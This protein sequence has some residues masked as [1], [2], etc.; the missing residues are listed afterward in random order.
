LAPLVRA[1]AVEKGR[2]P[3]VDSISGVSG[4]GKTPSPR[5]HFCE[6]SVQ[7][8]NVMKHRHNPEIDQACGT[9]VVFTPHLG[10]YSRG[11]VSTM[12]VDLAPGWTGA[13]VGETYKAAYAGEPFVRLLPAGEWPS[14]QGVE[15]TNFCDIGW[16]ADEAHRHL[17]VV[18]A[19]DNLVKGAAGQA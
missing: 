19:I 16:A 14:V 8:Y 12:H 10:P 3:I 9:P 1:G 2:R 6:V 7:P 15:R 18:S 11:I 5:T 13:R 4:A 17:I